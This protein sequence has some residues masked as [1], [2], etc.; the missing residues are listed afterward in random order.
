M[1]TFSRN[2]L[3]IMK[4]PENMKILKSRSMVPN[5]LFLIWT[6]KTERLGLNL[7]VGRT[8]K[9]NKKISKKWGE[10]VK[11]EK[12]RVKNVYE[13]NEERRKNE[14]IIKK[15]GKIE[16]VTKQQR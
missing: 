16:C 14:G 8:F 3:S 1:V 15:V 4:M 12:K 6:R 9:D 13:R 7:A 11:E 2:R 10:N 5:F